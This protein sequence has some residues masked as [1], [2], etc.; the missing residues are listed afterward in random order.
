MA[1]DL[2]INKRLFTIFA[3]ETFWMGRDESMFAL[4]KVD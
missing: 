2:E 4:G 3:P 1:I